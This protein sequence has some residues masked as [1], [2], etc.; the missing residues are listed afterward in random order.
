MKK[1]IEKITNKFK[2]SGKTVIITSHNIDELFDI[3]EYYV[4]IDSGEL[5]FEGSTEKL[6]IY[7]K[8]KILLN[9][10]FDKEG[11]VKFLNTL[12]IEFYKFDN[13]EN[14]VTISIRKYKQINYLFLYLVKQNLPIK[15]LRKIPINMESIHKAIEDYNKHS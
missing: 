6:N 8:Y 13:E 7:T 12:D 2:K 1:Q 14:A 3:I 5:L 4:V 10:S 9:D 15:N 11:F